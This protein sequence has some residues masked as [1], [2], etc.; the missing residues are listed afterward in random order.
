MSDNRHLPQE[1]LRHMVN[2]KMERLYA[3]LEKSYYKNFPAQHQALP[4]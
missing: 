2:R 3:F 4:N 1:V